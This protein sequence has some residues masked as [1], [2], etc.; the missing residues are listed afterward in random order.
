MAAIR[1]EIDSMKVD[2]FIET[3]RATNY[4]K[5]SVKDFGDVIVRLRGDIAPTTVENFKKLVAEGF[6]DGLTIH[7][8]VKGFAIQGGDP[9]GDGSGGSEDTIL[10]EFTSNGVRN[11]LSHIAGVISMARKTDDYN[12]ATSQFMICNA[13]A[14]ATLDGTHAAFGYVVAGYETV[15]MV[16]NVEVTLG[17]G[18]VSR[19]KETVTIEKICFVTQKSATASTEASPETNG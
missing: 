17:S 16:S 4:V 5:I 10:G 3:V 1:Q 14:T 13:D 6:Y 7:R 8:V 9:K 12:S 15:L 2:G 18:E 11:D 19:P